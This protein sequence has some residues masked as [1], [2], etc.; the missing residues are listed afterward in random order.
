MAKQKFKITNWRNHNKA[1]INR[2]SITFCV[3]DA[4]SRLMHL[5]FVKSESTFA[6]FEI[7]FAEHSTICAV[8]ILPCFKSI[9]RALFL[10][11]ITIRRND[12]NHQVP[13]DAGYSGV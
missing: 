11:Q 3:D 12:N 7:R 5:L 4:T 9:N 8:N 2:G 1:L 6:Y 10:M 13:G